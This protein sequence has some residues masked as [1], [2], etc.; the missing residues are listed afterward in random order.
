MA[1]TIGIKSDAA[2]TKNTIER[3]SKLLPFLDENVPDKLTRSYASPA[4]NAS[5]TKAEFISDVEEGIRAASMSIRLT[6]YIL[7]LID[8]RN[9]MTDPVRRQFLP[10]KSTMIGDHRLTQLDSL[11]EE[12]DSPV[13]NLVHRYPDKVLFLGRLRIL[14]TS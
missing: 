12:G 2:Q 3:K 10:L 7:S 13:K 1:L 4:A 6:P 11:D 9:P 8:W 5:V 14:S